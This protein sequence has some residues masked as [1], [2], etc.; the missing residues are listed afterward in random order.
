MSTEIKG[1]RVHAPF[2][3]QLTNFYWNFELNDYDV[4]WHRLQCKWRAAR[5]SGVLP[6]RLRVFRSQ[7]LRKRLLQMRCKRAIYKRAICCGPTY[8]TTKFGCCMKKRVWRR[9]C[10]WKDLRI[11]DLKEDQKFVEEL[12]IIFSDRIKY[13]L[14]PFEEV[15]RK[16][17]IEDSAK[18]ADR[19]RWQDQ[20]KTSKEDVEI[21]SRSYRLPDLSILLHDLHS[22][23]N[24][25]KNC[26]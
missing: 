17:L 18:E 7:P 12:K 5:N 11:K 14:S 25:K 9:I 6:S 8:K 24:Y 20:M 1:T 22:K 21:R 15:T 26:N 10:W 2:Q 13:H 4:T 19:S 23:K 3:Q 16:D